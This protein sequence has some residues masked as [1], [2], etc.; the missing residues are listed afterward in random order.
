MIR[1]IIGISHVE[2]LECISAATTR[3]VCEQH[4][5]RIATKLVKDATT[6]TNI[7]QVTAL[8]RSARQ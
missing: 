1:R 4:A 3:A 8:A 5:L 6:F 7:K 2:D